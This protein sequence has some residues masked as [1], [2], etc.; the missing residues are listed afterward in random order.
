MNELLTGGTRVALRVGDQVR[1][2]ARL[3]DV[4]SGAVIDTFKTDG[5]LDELE[6]LLAEVVVS[7]QV[8]LETGLAQTPPATTREEVL[9]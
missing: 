9:A 3:I 1:I 4:T 6:A 5:R 2:T 8:A 7:V